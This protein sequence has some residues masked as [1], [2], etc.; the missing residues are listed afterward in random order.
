MSSDLATKLA[1]LRKKDKSLRVG[2]IGELQEYTGQSFPT[3]NVAMDLALGVNGFPQGK[4]IELY[5]VSMSGKTTMALQTIAVH[6]ALVRAERAAGAVLYLDYEH[7][8]DQGYCRAL[9]IDTEDAE[10]FIYVQPES[11]EQGVQLFRDLMADRLLA[12]GVLD[13]VAA[14]VPQS[15]LEAVSGAVTFADRARG[16][17]QFFRQVKGKMAR[18][19]TSVIMLNHVMEKIDTTP[20]GRQLASKGIKRTTTP[21]GTSIEFYADVRVVFS[22][23]GDVKTKGLL[24]PVTQEEESLVTATDVEA[25]VLK[26][27]VAVPRKIA[28]M[29]V[30]YGK[31]F[32]EPYSVFMVLLGYGLIKKDGSWY[33]VSAEISPTDQKWQTQGEE[34][35]VS[36]LENDLDWCKKMED[37]ARTLVS[38]DDTP[39]E[40]QA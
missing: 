4:V 1:E 32:S 6:Q 24:N 16:L 12:F 10:T 25:L 40:Q 29:R 7:A 26:N 27:K 13:S 33:T 23:V 18:T 2:S 8:L 39:Q 28:R 14:M 15:E 11:F 36:R 9:G 5:G 20:M 17:H 37:L 21:G 22:R 34:S 35:V 38:D 31:G 30:R 19:G 3:G